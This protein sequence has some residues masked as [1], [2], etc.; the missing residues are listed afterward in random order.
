MR[1][2]EH[3]D[4]NSYLNSAT[5]TSFR[6]PGR[7]KIDYKHLFET[8]SFRTLSE[9]G[10]RALPEAI[11][12]HNQRGRDLKLRTTIDSKTKVLKARIV[13][14]KVADLHIF[15]PGPN[16]DM[17][18]SINIEC[19]LIRPDL[20]PHA[21]TKE[22][23]PQE[24][25]QPDRKKDRLSYKQLKYS[26]DLTRVDVAGMPPKYELEIEVDAN[27]LRQE[28]SKMLVGQDNGFTDIVDGFME[29]AQWLMKQVKPGI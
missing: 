8:D 12:K 23:N 22:P 13:K 17:R 27:A 4:M 11:H 19:N 15:N 26:V 18:I 25:V 16:Y 10:L 29:N 24:P 14:V 21:L 3:K 28:M 6:E 1:Q 7:E 5:Q 2:A 9:V 20:D